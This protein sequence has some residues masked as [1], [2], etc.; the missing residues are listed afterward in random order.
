MPN[1]LD[2]TKMIVGFVAGSSAAA[3]TKSVLLNNLEDPESTREKMDIVIGC[4]VIGGLVGNAAGNYAQRQ[5]D[6]IANA[7]RK[8]EPAN[9]EVL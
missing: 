5:V 4:A 1:Y 7:F 3:V 9:L 6:T 2:A 8:P